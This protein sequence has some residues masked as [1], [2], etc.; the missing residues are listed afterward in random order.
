MA[1]LLGIRTLYRFLTRRLTVA[2]AEAKVNEITGCRCRALLGAPAALA[3][4]VDG[5]EDYL[6]AQQQMEGSR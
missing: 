1:Q 4:D 6:W 5:Y 3:A 2:E